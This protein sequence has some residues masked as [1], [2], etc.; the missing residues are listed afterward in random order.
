MF[1]K[2]N[3][4]NIVIKLNVRYQQSCSFCQ[5]HTCVTDQRHQPPD[6]I[7][8]FKALLLDGAEV[9]I[10]DWRTN[11]RLLII[12]D[13]DVGENVGTGKAILSDGKIGDGFDCAK[14]TAY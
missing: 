12:W 3:V 11:G 8:Q 9:L 1:A 2:G 7:I 14:D 4:G 10:G 5:A 6:I 13:E